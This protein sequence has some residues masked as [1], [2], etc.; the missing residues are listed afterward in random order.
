MYR[1]PRKNIPLIG[2]TLASQITNL[3]NAC[4]HCGFERLLIDMRPAVPLG[5]WRGRDLELLEEAQIALVATDHRCFG[6]TLAG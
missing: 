4:R 3:L 5:L 6:A 2:L 1:N